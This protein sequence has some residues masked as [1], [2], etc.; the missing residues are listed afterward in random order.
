MSGA[1]R[2]IDWLRGLQTSVEEATT[3]VAGESEGSSRAAD[4]AVEIKARVKEVSLQRK[5]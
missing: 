3:C 5:Q 2:L 1:A 4:V